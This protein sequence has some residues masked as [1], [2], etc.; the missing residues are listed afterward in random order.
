MALEEGGW[1]R[2]LDPGIFPVEGG[3]VTFCGLDGSFFAL[4][5]GFDLWY[6]PISVAK[7]RQHFDFGGTP[8]VTVQ[9]RID[10]IRLP[11]TQSIFR[12]SG[13]RMLALESRA[14]MLEATHPTRPRIFM[15]GPV[16]DPPFPTGSDYV[17]LRTDAIKRCL[18]NDLRVVGCVKRISDRFL[19]RLVSGMVEDGMRSSL[20]TFPNDFFLVTHAFAKFRSRRGY[21]AA[22]YT[23][24]ID[25]SLEDP[26]HKEYWECGIGVSC[27]FFQKDSVS[28]IVRLDIP[29]LRGEST[30]PQGILSEEYNAVLGMVNQLTLPAQSYPVPVVLAHEKC[31]VRQGAAEVLYMEIMTRSATVSPED[32][33]TLMQLR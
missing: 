13:I 14:L 25:V 7:V 8:D 17:T 28:R 9:A 30:T 33:V 32:F 31:K 26:T 15:D 20:D 19:G 22:I 18:E 27:G 24:P 1:L 29:Y 10:A 2:S 5:S 21:N 6:V 12:E 23:P 4:A 3:E 11:P 16:A